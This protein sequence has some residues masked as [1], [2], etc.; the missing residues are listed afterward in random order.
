MAAVIAIIWGWRLRW[1][2]TNVITRSLADRAK[3]RFHPVAVIQLAVTRGAAVGGY[4][5]DNFAV[6]AG[7]FRRSDA[8]DGVSRGGESPYYA[9]SDIAASL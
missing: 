8:V 9:T 3:S 5:L 6:A 7:A 1:P 2:H 4:A